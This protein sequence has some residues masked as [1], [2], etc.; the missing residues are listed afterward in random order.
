MSRECSTPYL[1]DHDLTRNDDK[2]NANEKPIS[3]HTF[4]YVEFVV[5]SSIVVLIEYLHPNKSIEYQSRQLPL[6]AVALI[7]EEGCPTEIQDECDN[8]LKDGLPDDHLPHSQGDQGGRL[9]FGF[10]IQDTGGR[11]VSSQSERSK[12]IHDQVHPKKL[13]RGQDRCLGIA[14]HRRYKSEYDCRNVDCD[15]ELFEISYIFKRMIDLTHLEELLDGVV[16]SSTP[17]DCFDN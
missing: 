5:E 7:R 12:R 9:G 4:E 10:A 2:L 15:L 1:Y 8:E 16:D 3:L 6:F 17:H 13:D 11:R 14:G